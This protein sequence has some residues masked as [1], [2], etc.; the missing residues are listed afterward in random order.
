MLERSLWPQSAV[1]INKQNP[2][3]NWRQE[4]RKES[5]HA[6]VTQL[7]LMMPTR[8]DISYVSITL[9]PQLDEE[10]IPFC[11]LQPMGDCRNSANEKSLHPTFSFLQ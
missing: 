9:L 3:L 10:K 7:T 11:P 6:G 8:R 5:F 4:A 1:K 2:Y